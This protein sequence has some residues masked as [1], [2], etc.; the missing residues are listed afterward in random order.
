[1]VFSPPLIMSTFLVTLVFLF[2][3]KE[4]LIKAGILDC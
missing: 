3:L 1:M 2:S 4:N